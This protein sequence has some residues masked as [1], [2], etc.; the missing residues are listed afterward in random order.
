MNKNSK[1]TAVGAF[2]CSLIALA[3][4]GVHAQSSVTIYGTVDANIGSYKGAAT[5]I[6]SKSVR[7]WQQEAGGMTTSFF[8]IKGS[9][10]L[11]GGLKAE[12]DLQSFFRNDTG[13]TGRADAI[14]NVV[15]ADPFFSKASWVGFSSA[16]W[17]KLRLGN[18]ITPLFLNSISSNA[19]G[20]STVFS[21][22]NLVTFVGSPLSGGTN[23][24]NTVFYETPK[25]GGVTLS[26]NHSF[27][28]G[29]GGANTGVRGTYASGAFA[30]SAVWTTVKRDPVTFSDGTTRDN[31]R[32]FQLA[33]SYDFQVVKLFAHLGQTKVLAGTGTTTSDVTHDIWGLSASAPLGNGTLLAGMASRKGDETGGASKRTVISLGYDYALS[34]RTDLYAVIRSDKTRAAATTLDVSGTSYAA[35]FRHRF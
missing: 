31:T 25:L 21:P 12:F 16:D 15:A 17:G 4:Q 1:S 34:K 19:F 11:G 2:A 9:E 32:N 30:A 23:W 26:V 28:E 14:P 7:T 13:S 18:M 29:E 20:D 24:K 5:G 3:C 8:G 6:T 33:A 35:G 22:I 10:D 27:S